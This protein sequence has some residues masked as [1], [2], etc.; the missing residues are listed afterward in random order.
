MHNLYQIEE[1]TGKSRDMVQNNWPLDLQN[2][3]MKIKDGGT[4]MLKES[5]E[6]L[7]KYNK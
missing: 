1:A 7:I 6:M 4:S 3:S 5:K 2:S